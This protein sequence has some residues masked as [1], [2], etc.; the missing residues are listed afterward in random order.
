MSPDDRQL[1]LPKREEEILEFWE[2]NRIFEKTL[3]NTK[4]G[5]PFI[6]YEGPP[7]ANGLP[8]IHHFEARVFKDII[9]RYRTMQGF[10][11]PRKAGWDTHGLPIEMEVEKQ[12]GIK[13]KRDIEEKIGIA[14][15]VEAARANVFRYKAEWE[16]FTRRIGYWLD[17]EHAY[18][19][20][21][22]DY[23]ETLWWI[24]KEFWKKNL[25]YQDFKVLPWCP[26]CQ[27]ALSTHELGQGYETV[28]DRSVYVRFRLKSDN[29]R[30]RNAA[31]LSWTTTPWTLPG[32]VALAVNP[33]EEYVCV[34]DP[35]VQGH[36]LVLGQASFKQ[37]LAKKFFSPEMAAPPAGAR[38][39]GKRLGMDR[40]TGKEML[41]IEYEP[42]FAVKELRSPK[43]HRVY[44]AD[45]VS[46]K[47]GTGVV[48]TAVMYGEDDYRLG[49]KVGLPKFHTVTET[50]HFIKEV[51]EGLGGLYVKDPKTE[52]KVIA[53]LKRRGLLLA[54]ER[55][56]HDYPFCWRCQTPLLYYA[57]QGW[58]V[59]MTAKRRAL[60]ANN[61][62]IN[63][64]PEHLK[65]GRF[66]E[67]LKEVRDWAFSRERY[68]GTPLP[69][70]R[71]E[72]CGEQEVIGS[73]K[74]LARNHSVHN[75]YIGM[76]H[77]EAVN[78][79]KNIV[80]RDGVYGL[81]PRGRKQV[82]A[83]AKELSAKKID[84]I[85]SSTV[86]RAKETA[87]IVAERLRMGN[88]RFD[89]RLNEINFG[90]LE[91]K[92][93]QRYHAL[94]NGAD[95]F[96]TAPPGGES[97][98]DVRKR[99]F[100]L[101]SDL[102]KRYKGKRILFISHHDPLQLLALGARGY[103]NQEI[104]QLNEVNQ[105]PATH[106]ERVPDSIPFAGC[107]PVEY[108]LLPRNDFGEVDLHRPYVDTFEIKCSKCGGKKRRVSEVVDVWF[109]SGAMPFAQGHWPFAQMQNAKFK[110]Q[111]LGTLLYPADY[112]CEGVDQTR[113]W[114]YTLLAVST[115]LGRGPSYKNVLSLG[116][117]LDKNG[118][119]MSKS[120]GN[121][122]DPWALIAKYGTD[123]IRWYFYTINA[124]G[125]PKR[126]DEKDIL[127]KL[128]GALATLWHSFVFFDTY[129]P[130]IQ[131]SKF[132][133]QNSRNVLDQWVAAKLDELTAEVTRRLDSYD[134]VGAARALDAFITEDFSNWYLR[135]SRRRFQ[136]PE[137]ASEKAEAARVTGYV[138]TCIATL[139]APF[140]PFLAEIIYR[141]LKKKLG[142]KEESVHLRGWP[143][144]ALRRIR[145]AHHRHAQGGSR[146]LAGM[147]EVRRLAALALAERARAGIKVRQPLGALRIKNQ[148]AGRRELLDVLK[149]EVNVKNV[150]V[151]PKVRGEVE[152]DTALTPELREEGLVRE[153]V[154]NIQE[155]RR[156]A[157]L[158]PQQEIR[159]QVSGDGAVGEAV[160]RWA[161]FIQREAG[162]R[163]VGVGGKKQCTVEREA[164][165]DGQHVWVGIR[166]A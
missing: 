130:K 113:G 153:L 66:G 28:K 157:G 115:L 112:I 125:D 137:S 48:H 158:K 72:R 79:V 60:I 154:R 117:V 98:Q 111:N 73:R 147:A 5:K 120:K 114:F 68:W 51:G 31:V 34:P 146:L 77:G 140:T 96:S 136:R 29:P 142:L 88:V 39:D 144:V 129:V 105:G 47:E 145:P 103:S 89:K 149:D 90:I 135:R 138:I 3:E 69:V 59:K 119:K 152:L 2:R 151:D 20:M 163:A 15:F 14:T 56:E 27:T 80:A 160:G 134:I 36:W 156:D 101:L 67:F 131:N 21:A 16:R 49:T 43:A 53:S 6:F 44:G 161:K 17:L 122:V 76:R 55:Y 78:N 8:G 99:T 100:E 32:N 37:L 85:I 13:T 62:K 108:M 71:C 164:K 116:H 126:F 143:R 95:P 102:E 33:R 118:Q 74:E 30:W 58:W 141:E 104:L 18:M 24:I 91:G 41:G 124:P 166:N 4:R 11:V 97:L 57:R 42:L 106:T 50:G 10:F 150:V 19:T 133:I 46:I 148:E 155:M 35:E 54:E 84:I 81:T 127:L 92:P 63:W 65:R 25:L 165:L 86:L 23:I 107:I 12:L 82:V 45:F 128:R 110:V 159:V 7:Y 162:A 123:T 38:H 40:F 64:M 132:K 139:M 22:P 75:T 1:N 93:V 94:L 9:I 121:A 87:H 52:E 70:W 61:E 109:D 26:R 83:A